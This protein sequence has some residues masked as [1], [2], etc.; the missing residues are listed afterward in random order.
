MEERLEAEGKEARGGPC[1][2]GVDCILVVESKKRHLDGE[3][4]RSL[5]S[6]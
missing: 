4:D 3:E 2:G 6:A 1:E 5:S